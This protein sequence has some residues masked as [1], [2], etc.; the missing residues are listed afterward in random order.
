MPS[1]YNNSM[2]NLAKELNK[3]DLNSSVRL[4]KKKLDGYKSE[5]EFVELSM[6]VYV[7]DNG[8]RKSNP[9]FVKS[10]SKGNVD[11]Y[12][13]EITPDS[14]VRCFMLKRLILPG[15]GNK[16]KYSYDNEEFEATF[17]FFFGKSYR[18]LVSY[19]R[20]FNYNRVVNEMCALNF[21]EI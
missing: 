12:L 1:A 7:L 16:E 9:P 10:D 20:E 14:K 2:E 18:E 3:P 21:Y 6:K 4:V 15:Y 11:E 5:H 8:W 17:E 13:T 19:M